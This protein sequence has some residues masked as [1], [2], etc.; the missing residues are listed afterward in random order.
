MVRRG[1][2]LPLLALDVDMPP[3]RLQVRR[4]KPRSLSNARQHVR[5]Y[6]FAIV[7]REHEVGPA[8]SLQGT[9]RA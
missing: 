6:I 4:G 8:R 5:T 7:K 2:T 9:V 3:R 1:R